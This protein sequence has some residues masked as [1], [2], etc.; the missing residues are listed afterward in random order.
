MTDALNMDRTVR[1]RIP[2]PAT[3][4]SF[5]LAVTA[6]NCQQYCSDGMATTTQNTTQVLA[7]HIVGLLSCSFRDLGIVRLALYIANPIITG[8]LGAFNNRSL[9]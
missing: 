9:G 8:P 6:P 2:Q 1:L 7:Y 4:V 3:A 5:T